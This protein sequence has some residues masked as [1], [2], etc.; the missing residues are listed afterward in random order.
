MWMNT[1]KWRIM[2]T[3]APRA[4]KSISPHVVRF[5][6]TICVCMRKTFFVRCLKWADVGKEYIEVVKGNLQR[7]F[8][9]DFNDQAMNSIKV[10]PTWYIASAGQLPDVL[11]CISI[12]DVGGG[13]LD[14]VLVMRREFL[15]RCVF[16]DVRPDTV[17]DVG[18]RHPDIVL[19]S[20][21]LVVNFTAKWYSFPAMDR[22]FEGLARK[23]NN[24]ICSKADIDELNS[25]VEEFEVND[26]PSYLFFKD[27]SLVEKL[28]RPCIDL[29]KS[30]A[31][32]HAT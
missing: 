26:I 14:V 10:L 22:V 19:A 11:Y 20:S 31:S 13:I 23:M 16:T 2:M 8:V 18:N 32:K 29:L 24:V 12:S 28:Q 9:L 6:Q 27:G 30:T 4:E 17:K 3:I 15:Y 1:V 7:F 5:S 25:V 21:Y